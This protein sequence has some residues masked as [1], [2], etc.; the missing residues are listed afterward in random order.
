MGLYIQVG[1]WSLGEV[2]WHDVGVSYWLYLRW[3]A[4]SLPLTKPFLP[5]LPAFKQSPTAIP[6]VGT[7]VKKRRHGDEDMYYMHVSVP[8][9]QS[10]GW[11]SQ[12]GD[13]GGTGSGQKWPV[14]LTA[15]TQGSA[16]GKSTKGEPGPREPDQTGPD[17][18]EDEGLPGGQR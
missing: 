4:S 6:T 7:N 9:L 8:C 17:H 11:G 10:L 14:T 2:G 13:P 1:Y 3:P 5:G 18:R 12:R 15:E 16:G